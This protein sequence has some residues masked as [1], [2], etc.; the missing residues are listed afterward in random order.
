MPGLPVD[1]H[2][3]RISYLLGMTESDKADEVEQD[4]CEMLPKSAW[5][6][7]AHLIQWHGRRCCKAL[8]PDCE[9]CVI[10]DLCPSAF[11]AGKWANDPEA[12]KAASK[13]TLGHA[14]SAGKVRAA[15]EKAAARK[16]ASKKRAAAKNK[17]GPKK[18][19]A[20]RKPADQKTTAKKKAARKKAAARSRK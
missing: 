8:A 4:L 17:A 14:P 16:A 9:A 11:A 3:L 15:K 6:R 2:V 5:T 7:F 10:N 1:T 18:T 20:A 12:A 19:K 13:R